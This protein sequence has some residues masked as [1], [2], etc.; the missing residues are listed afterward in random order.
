MI[1]SYING[2][3][4]RK[5]DGSYEGSITIDGITLP[6]ITAQYFTKDGNTYLW[7]RRKKVLDYNDETM[8]FVEREAKPKW[9]CYL[10]KQLDNETVAYKGEFFFMRFKFSIV[11]V[12]D[13]VFGLDKQRRLNLFIER[14]PMSQQTIINNINE[15]KRKQNG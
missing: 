3:I 4:Q 12:W 1:D 10:Q 13:A 2:Y 15:Q 5:H 11:G 9:E 14:L 7:L 6:N 8:R